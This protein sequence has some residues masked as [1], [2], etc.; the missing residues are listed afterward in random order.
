MAVS[1]SAVPARAPARTHTFQ[2]VKRPSPETQNAT[3]RRTG[4]LCARAKAT[5]SSVTRCAPTNRA[6]LPGPRRS[7]T[8]RLNAALR[9]LSSSPVAAAAN[10]PPPANRIPTALNCA[11]PAYT[12]RDITTGTHT[13]SP[14]ATEI[15]PKETPTTPPAAQT[16]ETSRN[17]AGS[18]T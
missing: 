5:V 14:P 18:R 7:A 11:A 13:G 9:V 3:R 1:P 10:G 16:R 15:A 2:T 17:K 8:A 12:I 4:S 6:V